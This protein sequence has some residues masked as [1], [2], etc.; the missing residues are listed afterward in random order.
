[1]KTKGLFILEKKS[2]R[3]VRTFVELYILFS[4]L[5]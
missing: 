3:K 2:S 4:L 5:W 1:L